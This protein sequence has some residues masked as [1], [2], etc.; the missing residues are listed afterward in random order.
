MLM[1]FVNCCGDVKLFGD[2]SLTLILILILCITSI[3]MRHALSV[4]LYGMM[5]FD[6][7][8]MIRLLV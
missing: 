5:S 2:L 7:C 4:R 6:C 8:L 3:F 1:R